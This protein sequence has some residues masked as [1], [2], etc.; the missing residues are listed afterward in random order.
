MNEHI[1]QKMKKLGVTQVELIK[2][3]HERGITVQPPEMSQI[4]SGVMIAAR[5]RNSTS[6]SP[7]TW[8]SNSTTPTATS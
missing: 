3:L 6:R 7:A 1:R 4:I 8:R 5:I 2:K